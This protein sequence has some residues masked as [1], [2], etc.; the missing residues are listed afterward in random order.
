MQPVEERAEV[1]ML[2][3]LD[4]AYNLARWL[5]RDTHDAEDVVQEAYMRAYKRFSTFRGGDVRAWLL[6]IVRNCAYD[7]LRS[8]GSITCGDAFGEEGDVARAPSTCEPEAALLRG[9]KAEQV[10][11]AL[12]NLLPQYREVLIL[13]EMEELSYSEIATT[14][15][16]PLG[17]VMSRLSRARIR[18]HQSLTAQG[19]VA[20]TH[21]SGTSS[22][23]VREEYGR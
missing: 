6:A 21:P 19:G 13:R 10:R 2:R 16:V 11:S 14:I 20:L 22:P 15:G 7:L 8:S 23:S 3:H 4:A 9:E 5:M 17:T 18:L 12:E 1:Q